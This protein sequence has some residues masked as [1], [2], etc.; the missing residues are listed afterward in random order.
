MKVTYFQ[1]VPYR[2]L[3]DDFEKHARVCCHHPVLR[4]DRNRRRS[5]RAFRDALDEIMH[6]ARAG[7]DAIAITEHGQ[8]SY[9]MAPNPNIL[10]AAAAY[11]TE[12]GGLDHRHLPA[13]PIPGQEPANRFASP[14]NWRCSTRSVKRTPG[15]W[16][17]RRPRLRRQHQQRRPAGRDPGRGST[18]TSNWFSGPGR[19]RRRSPG[20]AVSPARPGQPL[21][22]PRTAEPAPPGVDHRHRQPAHHAI[23]PRARTSG[24]TTS[25]GSARR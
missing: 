21:A 2:H 8:S 7:F 23:L 13:G 25:A 10:E 11:A 12:A 9:D 24:S 16:L 4:A 18:R 15:R 3:P 17:P 6:A 1:Q 14:R 19:S 20:T 5:T 22:A